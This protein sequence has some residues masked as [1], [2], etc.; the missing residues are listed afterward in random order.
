MKNEK[1]RTISIAVAITVV[2]LFISNVSFGQA[3]PPPGVPLDFGLSGL[4]ALCVGYGAYK[5]KNKD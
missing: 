1:S 2:L 5:N 4:I 3:P